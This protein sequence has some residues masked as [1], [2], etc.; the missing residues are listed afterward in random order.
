MGE[1]P[2]VLRSFRDTFAAQKKLADGAIAQLRDDQLRTALAP[3]LNSVAII[4]QHLGGN[5]E[6]R[7]GPGWLELDG[8]RPT[9]D[10]D[11]EFAD[12]ALPR[13]DL[14]ALWERGWSTLLGALDALR[15]EDL[16]RTV[17]IRGEPHPLPLAL[18]RAL[19]HA[20]Y[21]TGQITMIA[22]GVAGSEGWKW[23]TIA[24][25]ESRAFNQSKGFSPRRTA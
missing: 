20:G 24:P 23:L 19:A 21:H 25:G 18:A 6:S 5:F 15:P 17:R 8:E 11:A 22:R 1:A 9:R 14:L 12:R 7:F 16:A 2:T 10:R 3:G 13:A 4:M